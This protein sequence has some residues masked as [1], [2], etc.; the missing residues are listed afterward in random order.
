MCVCLRVCRPP[1]TSLP[2]HSASYRTALREFPGPGCPAE[3][4]L[5]IAA[6]SFKLGDLATAKAAYK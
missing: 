4:R 2:S 1:P 3:V 5:G 6:A